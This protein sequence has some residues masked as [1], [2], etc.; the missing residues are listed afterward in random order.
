MN[1][2]VLLHDNHI[3]G[4]TKKQASPT[5]PLGTRSN[6]TMNRQQRAAIASRVV[7]CR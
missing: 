3:Y 7:G 2:T 6:T 4:L 1:M 5:S